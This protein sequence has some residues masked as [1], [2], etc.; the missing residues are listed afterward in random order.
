MPPVSGCQGLWT[1]LRHRPH[2]TRFPRTSDSGL[3]EARTV[4][5][6]RV[7]VVA[8]VAVC[9]LVGGGAAVTATA[10]PLHAPATAAGPTPVT[11]A[12]P[13]T[14]VRV[15][16]SFD[17]PTTPYGPGH[18]GVD[19][20][21]SPGGPVA[22][23]GAGT[24]SFAGSVAGRGVVV[25]VHPDGV[26][27]EYEPIVPAVHTGDAVRR[28]QF[29]G[30]VHGTHHDCRPGRCLHWGAKRDG[31]YIDPLSLLHPLGPVRLLPWTGARSGP[32]VGLL[33]GAAQP[34][35]RDV[36]VQLGGG[37]AGVAEQFLHRAQVRP[38]VEQVG[39][40][41]VA[42]PMRT[43]VRGARHTADRPM[44]HGS[45]SARI[46]SAASGAEHQGSTARGCGQLRSAPP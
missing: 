12:P 14:P 41:R 44:D 10:P 46:D 4:S 13:L 15:V 43:D 6:A 19:L 8:A 39:S 38:A 28:G 22:A 20:E 1:Q 31:E 45:H 21:S 2:P 32:G 33:V 26:S 7:R 34:V 36:C 27:T 24:V 17:P 25:I 37:Q 5:G 40:G 11:Y 30:T 9:A 18:L 42:Q 3:N 35:D 23:A 29:I 16:H